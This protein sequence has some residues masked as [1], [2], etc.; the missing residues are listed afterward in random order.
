[1]MMMRRKSLILQD[2]IAHLGKSRQLDTNQ[3][4]KRDG[5]PGRNSGG[6]DEL[7]LSQLPPDHSLA[8]PLSSKTSTS[9]RRLPTRSSWMSSTAGACLFESHSSDLLASLLADV[10]APVSQTAVHA[11]PHASSLSSLRPRPRPRPRSPFRPPTPSTSLT[12]PS[13]S[14]FPPPFPPCSHHVHS[15]RG[16]LVLFAAA[17][18]VPDEVASKPGVQPSQ[19]VLVLLHAGSSQQLPLRG[20]DS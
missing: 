19:Q 13:S 5:G 15:A 4:K 9:C 14:S 8:L 6:A 7:L 3:R 1:M 16:I 18:P 10:P 11:R 20:G 17:P 2:S 12:S